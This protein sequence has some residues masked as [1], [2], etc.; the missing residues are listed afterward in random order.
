M[1]IKNTSVLKSVEKPGRYS[2]GEYG[3]IIKDK[4]DI[5][6]RWAFCFPDTYEIGMSNLGVR[7]LYG[8]LN[9]ESDVWCERVYAPWTDMQEKMREYNIPLCAHESGDPVRDFDIVG[10]TLQYEMCYTTTLKMLE[11]AGMPLYAKDRGEEFPI[12]I[13]GGPCAYNPEPVADFFDCFSIGEGE[14]NLVEFTRLYIEMKENGTYTKKEFLHR[15][16]AEIGG[17]YVPS[18]YDVTYNDDGTIK[19]YTPIYSDVPKRVLKRIMTDMDKA[20]FPSKVVMPYIETVHD[21]IMLEVYRGCI[22]GCRFCQAG[23]VYRPVRE[24]TPGVL[25][26]QAKCLFEATGYDEISLSSLSISD[27]SRL[28]ELTDGLL[29]WTDNNMVSLSLP[30]LRVDSF[31]KELMEKISTVRTGGLT[32]APE[33]GSQRL[34]DVINKNVCESDLLRAVNVGFD[35]GKTSCKLYFMMGLPT[36]TY[37]DLDGIADLAKAVI[38]EYYANPNR[39]KGRAPSVTVSVSCFIPKPFTP[40][41]WE[42]QDSMETFLEKQKYLESKITDRKIRY[43]HHDARVSHVEAILAR[44]DRRLAPALALACERGFC[45]DA[46][47]EFF[48]YGEWIKAFEDCGIDYNFYSNRVWGEDE[49]LPWDVIDCGVTKEFLKRERKNAYAEKCTPSCREKCSGC[50]VNKLGG[51]RTWCPKKED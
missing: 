48:H 21:R 51:E 22:R 7:I 9:Q 12:V 40:F 45:F 16:S 4:K 10:I 19:A 27:Y 3:Q 6:T 47:D 36:E 32:F 37:E 28:D 15:A 17:I 20:Y 30:S 26:E 50:G 29:K 42:A 14:E 41:Q 8:A 34:R 1:N 23:M 33:A 39:Q 46:W 44:G 13:G 43:V 5:K 2:A 49:V 31:T 25:N 38:E 11:L 18:L 35:A 24:K